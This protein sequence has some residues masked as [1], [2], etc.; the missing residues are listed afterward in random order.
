MYGKFV[1][2]IPN[3]IF[4]TFGLHHSLESAFLLTSTNFRPIGSFLL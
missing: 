4:Q 1:Q 2:L 3:S